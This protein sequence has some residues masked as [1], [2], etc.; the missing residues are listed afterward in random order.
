MREGPWTWR[1]SPY[2]TMQIRQPITLRSRASNSSSKSRSRSRSRSEELLSSAAWRID[3]SFSK[4]IGCAHCGRKGDNIGRE[5]FMFFCWMLRSDTRS[6]LVS[7]LREGAWY[8][9]FSGFIVLSPLW[10]YPCREC[11]YLDYERVETACNYEKSLCDMEET[12]G[13]YFDFMKANC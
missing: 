3:W 1:H 13:E 12:L 2:G 11:L 4:D 8:R 5:P 10:W 7:L 9:L 6:R